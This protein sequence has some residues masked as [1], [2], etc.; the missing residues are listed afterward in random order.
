M[1]SDRGATFAFMKRFQMMRPLLVLACIG[2]L[3][4][5]GCGMAPGK[6][7]SASH[8]TVKDGEW[9]YHA[10]DDTQKKVYDAFR[11]SSEDPFGQ[12]LIPLAIDKGEDGG[13]S[14][15]PIAEIDTVYQGFLYDH[16][17]L[18]WLA[19]TY[20]YQLA[21]LDADGGEMA[22]AVA[23]IPISETPEA[24]AA[25]K[26]AFEAA[27]KEFLTGIGDPDSDREYAKAVYER[28]A[29]TI[30][31]TGEAMYDDAM[32][33][34][35]TAYGALVEHKAVCDGFALAY[36]YLLSQRGI[37]CLVVPGESEGNPHTWNVAK[38]DGAWH[39]M[40]L[41]FDASLRDAGGSQY[42]DLTTEEMQA[43]HQRETNG[44]AVL[45]PITDD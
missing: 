4:C 24:L 6:A 25:H 28:M 31:Y 9:F 10:F 29:G 17:E 12:A 22:D 5:V 7:E 1:K 3:L 34:Q 37:P 18:F 30:E 8:E 16:P 33:M 26:E 15:I 32:Q 43:D 45:I 23:V 42:F 36:R 11:A 44:I 27:A 21:G 38:W 19:T 39:E 20:S 14:G 13:E 41:T 35:H 2:W 40:D